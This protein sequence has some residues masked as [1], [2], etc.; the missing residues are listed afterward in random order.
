MALG[1]TASSVVGLV[2]RHAVRLAAAAPRSDSASFAAMWL[3]SSVI[4]LRTVALL[5]GAAFAAGIAVVVAAT[6]LAAYQPAR[7][8]TRVDPAHALRTDG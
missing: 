8:A 4:R 1:A 7:G 5:D 2:I 3:L 6:A